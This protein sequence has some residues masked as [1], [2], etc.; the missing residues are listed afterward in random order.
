MNLKKEEALYLLKRS[1]RPEDSF[2]LFKKASE[3]R[4]N[5]IGEKLW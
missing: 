3:V 5:Q 1:R 4:N 2:D